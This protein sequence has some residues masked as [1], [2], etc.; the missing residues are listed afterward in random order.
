MY[1]WQ[2]KDW[3]IELCKIIKIFLLQD[4]KIEG[5]K[6]NI[7]NLKLEKSSATHWIVP[8]KTSKIPFTRTL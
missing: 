3:N 7:R 5:G 2:F 8:N 1:I 4:T 6:K